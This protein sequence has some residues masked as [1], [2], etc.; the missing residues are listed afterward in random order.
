MTQAELIEALPAGRLPPELTTLHPADLLALFG[1][2]LIVAALVS[3]S[4]MPFVKRRLSRKSLIRAT[5]N[6][7]PEERLLAIAR[8]LGH[9]P[10]D[11]R[12]AAYGIG[13]MPTGEE[14]EQAALRKRPLIPLARIS[15]TFRTDNDPLGPASP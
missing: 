15:R 2:G 14:M 8:V 6:L 13:P 7:P 5:L 3:L 12:P 4:S 10:D 9:L 1:L 11:L